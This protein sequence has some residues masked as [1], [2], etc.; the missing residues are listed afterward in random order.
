MEANEA[1]WPDCSVM[2]GCLREPNSM[3]MVIDDYKSKAGYRTSQRDE[4]T[5]LSTLSV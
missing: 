1:R 5:D 2:P 3:L 4:I